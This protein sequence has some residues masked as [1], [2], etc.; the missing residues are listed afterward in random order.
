MIT[1][2]WERLVVTGARQSQFLVW[3]V[4]KPIIWKH[5]WDEMF[6]ASLN[7][8]LRLACEEE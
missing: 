4:D 8:N 2:I 6:H 5:V 1:C 3:R 7:L